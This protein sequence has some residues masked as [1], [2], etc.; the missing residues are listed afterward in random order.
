MTGKELF[1]QTLEGKQS[2]AYPFM[3]I[4]MM[5]ASDKI[6]K[7]YRE[8]ATDARTQVAGQL[9]I[10][11]EFET[12]HISVISDPAVEASGLYIA[13]AGCEVSRGTPD[14]NLKAMSE[15]AKRKG[16]HGAV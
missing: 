16:A 8:Y 9:A 15:F 2:E 13:G 4:T 14:V 6:G 3:P 11:E 1:F 5:F 12:S 7:P 10:A